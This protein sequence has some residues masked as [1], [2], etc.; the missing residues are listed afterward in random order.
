MNVLD[1]INEGRRLSALLDESLIEHDRATR[2]AAVAESD[3]KLTWAKAYL[4]AAGPVKQREATADVESDQ[5]R[6][7]YRLADGVRVGALESIRSRRQ[8]VSLLQST[9]AAFRA[10]AEI[11]G[12]GPQYGP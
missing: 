8:Q 2:E 7:R 9:A 5:E 4:K 11:G 3:F 1:I 6:R 12:K 10:E